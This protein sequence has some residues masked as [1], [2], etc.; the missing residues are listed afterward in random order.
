[1]FGTGGMAVELV[2]DV[3]LRLAPLN[4]D[5]VFDL[6]RGVESYAVSAGLRD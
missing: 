6:V 1:M 5:E 2:K 3:S 4:R